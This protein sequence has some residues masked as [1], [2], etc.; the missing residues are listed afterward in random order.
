MSDFKTLLTISCTAD[1]TLPKDYCKCLSCEKESLPITPYE[2][3]HDSGFFIVF[4]C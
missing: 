4:F 3:Q 1:F 2:S